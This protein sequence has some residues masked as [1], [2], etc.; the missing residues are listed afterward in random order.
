MAYVKTENKD[1]DESLPLNPPLT[2]KIS[3]GVDK[4][5]YWAKAQYNIVSKQENI[6]PSF[7]ETVT[8]GCQTFDVKLG[9]KPFKKLILGLACLKMFDENYTNHLN[10][11]YKNQADLPMTRINEPGRNFT[12]F[13]QYKF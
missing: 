9:V 6:A 4:E 13:L 12:A 7:G 5:K 10:F 2:S 8:K 11:S 3:V 1:L